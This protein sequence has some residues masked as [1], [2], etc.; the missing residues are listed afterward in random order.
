MTYTSIHR[1]MTDGPRATASPPES[2]LQRLEHFFAAPLDS[3]RLTRSITPRLLGAVGF[4]RGEDVVIDPL[5]GSLETPAGVGVLVHEIAHVMQQRAGLV[6]NLSHGGRRVLVDCVDLEASANA[7]AAEFLCGRPRFSG[8][9]GRAWPPVA[10]GA[11]V[12]QCQATGALN[13]A[14]LDQGTMNPPPGPITFSANNSMNEVYGTR[15]AAFNRAK[16]LIGMLPTSVAKRTYHW[17]LVAGGIA[18]GEGQDINGGTPPGAAANQRTGRYYDFGHGKLIVEH[19]DDPNSWT[20]VGGGAPT[21]RGHFHIASYEVA[22]GNQKSMYLLHGPGFGAAP[23]VANQPPVYAW[24]RRFSF[25]QAG[26][27]ATGHHIYYF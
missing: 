5:L 13:T 22:S 19:P 25:E 24:D 4:A 9:G 8:S 23:I 12:V 1:E 17:Y 15:V 3:V 20:S 6:P 18:N 14:Y 10:P 27:G 16:A 2:I 11:A 7:A 21:L 26:G